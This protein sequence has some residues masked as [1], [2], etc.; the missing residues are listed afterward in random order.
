MTVLPPKAEVHPR[1]RYVAKV[2]AVIAALRRT[3]VMEYGKGSLG[4][5]IR[6]LDDRRP[7]GNFALHQRGE[8]LLTSLCLAWNVAADI[9]K[10]PAHVVVVECPVERIGEF[11]E[12]RLW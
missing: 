10:T 12:D 4:F 8:W 2:L 1:Y 5:G 6:G 9:D 7:A 11:V 3:T